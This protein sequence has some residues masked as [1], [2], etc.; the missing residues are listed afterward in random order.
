MLREK[1]EKYINFLWAIY[2]SR[3][4]VNA[5]VKPKQCKLLGHG[6]TVLASVL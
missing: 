1:A 2:F 4:L 5:Y 6:N 3:K